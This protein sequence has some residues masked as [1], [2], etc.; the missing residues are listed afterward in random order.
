MCMQYLKVLLKRKKEPVMRIKMF[1]VLLDDI[2]RLD[3]RC[4]EE[5]LC[6]RNLLGSSQETPKQSV[7]KS[8]SGF[9][10]F[11]GVFRQQDATGHFC[12]PEQIAWIQSHY[13]AYSLKWVAKEMGIGPKALRRLLHSLKIKT[14]LRNIHG[15]YTPRPSTSPITATDVVLDIIKSHSANGRITRTDV[16]RWAKRQRLTTYQ[17]GQVLHVLQKRKN[18][19][20]DGDLI[21]TSRDSLTSTTPAVVL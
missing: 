8:A 13:P 1:R 19:V 14:V 11:P 5:G 10:K 15:T 18:I 12:T 7:T 4:Q 2:E 9:S 21:C 17:V 20:I 6:L 16:R 3:Q